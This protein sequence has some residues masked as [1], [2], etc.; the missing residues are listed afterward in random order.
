MLYHDGFNQGY[1]IFHGFTVSQFH[2][3]NKF[4]LARF[5]YFF[6]LPGRDDHYAMEHGRIIIT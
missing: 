3:F 1:K 6:I 5:L 2:I 4:V